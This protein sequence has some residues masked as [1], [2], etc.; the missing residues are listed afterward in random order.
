[1]ADQGGVKGSQG[2]VG[3]IQEF[4]NEHGISLAARKKGVTSDA[5]MLSDGSRGR[6]NFGRVRD[7]PRLYKVG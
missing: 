1:M 5:G 2:C 3:V 7:R 6:C 4:Q